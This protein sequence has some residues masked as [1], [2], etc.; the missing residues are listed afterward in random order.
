MENN[1]YLCDNETKQ[2]EMKTIAKEIINEIKDL[3]RDYAVNI[4]DIAQ[5]VCKQTRCNLQ[6]S[7]TDYREL[8]KL[9]WRGL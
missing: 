1:V 2:T 7:D 3:S 6:L 9:V 8:T 4:H 5:D